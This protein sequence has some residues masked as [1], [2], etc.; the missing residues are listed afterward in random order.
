MQGWFLGK[1]GRGR[2]VYWKIK[3]FWG[4][5]KGKTVVCT[6]SA[7]RK[8][9]ME[10]LVVILHKKRLALLRQLLL[11]LEG[12]KS[13]PKPEKPVVEYPKEPDCPK[14]MNGKLTRIIPIKPIK[15]K[16]RCWD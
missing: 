9:T 15:V 3:C 6:H 2:F 14:C 4:G 10:Q 5:I 7:L 8:L 16:R 12:I 1:V 13:R 11:T